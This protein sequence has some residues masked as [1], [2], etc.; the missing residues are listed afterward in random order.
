MSDKEKT[1]F[2]F[3]LKIFEVVWDPLSSLPHAELFFCGFCL[4]LVPLVTAYWLLVLGLLLAE[5][6]LL[7]SLGFL[8]GLLFVLLGVWPAPIIALGLT[9][10]SLVRLPFNLFYQVAATGGT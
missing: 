1:L 6:L 4:V 3:F 2:K 5:L 7:L 10:I 9:A 8:L